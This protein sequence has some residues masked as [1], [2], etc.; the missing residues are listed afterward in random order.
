MSTIKYVTEDVTHV[1]HG[2]VAHGVNCQGVMGSGVAK[3][4][5]AKWPKAYEKYHEYVKHTPGFELNCLLGDMLIVDV[6]TNPLERVY[7]AN[8]F[9]QEQYGKDGKVYAD[10]VS[11][12]RSLDAALQ[13]TQGQGL[14]LYL[15]RIGC[16]LG[17][18]DWDTQVGP[19][20]E[21]LAEDY[22]IH[23]YVCDLEG[24]K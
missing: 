2:V 12:G 16:G 17:G 22:T 24:P 3:A 7:V 6:G 8:C 11:V 18:L 13:F 21:G 14:P 9:T 5:R 20:L 15:P 19:L 4:I 23:I 10:I 1:T